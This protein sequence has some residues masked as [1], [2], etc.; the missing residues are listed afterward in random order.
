MPKLGMTMAEGT[1]VEWPIAVGDYVDK[2]QIVLIIESEKAEVEIEATASGYFRHVYVEID[3]TVACGSLLAALTDTANEPFDASAFH[4]DNDTP[5]QPA[6]SVS[7]TAPSGEPGTAV[8]STAGRTREDRKPVA[9]AARAL[10]KK[11][12]FDVEAIVGSG[13]GGRVV[14]ADVESWAA[15]Y[16]ALVQVADG[17]RL[18]VPT[19]GSGDPVLLLPGFGTDVSVFARQIPPLAEGRRVLGVNPRGV[20]LSDAPEAERYDPPLLASDAAALVTDGPA[21]VI[22]AS[23]GAAV[24][25]EMALAYPDRVRSLTL[26]TPAVETTPRLEAVLES[27]CRLAAEASSEALATALLP[28]FF[29]DPSLADPRARRRI[30]SGLASIVGRVPALVLERYANGFAAWSGTRSEDLRSIP[31]PTLI[32]TGRDDLLTPGGERIAETIPDASCVAIADAG[33]ALSLEAP[34]A[35]NEALLAHLDRVTASGD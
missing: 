34:E 10:A 26:I 17:V 4:A 28:W 2:G 11:L 5:E 27:W 13:P 9:P 21:H 6:P 19:S 29:A 22:G 8:K 25:V 23:M 18:E 16:E 33:H 31:V 1:V 30:L 20:G 35:V 12:G 15:A 14:K 24:A 7:V 32:L 3:E